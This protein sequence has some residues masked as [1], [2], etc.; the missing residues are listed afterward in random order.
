MAETNVGKIGMDDFRW[1]QARLAE[2]SGNVLEDGRKFLAESRL[3]P[4]VLRHRLPGFAE[5][6]G[7]LRQGGQGDLEAEALDAMTGSDTW[8]FR[9][10]APFDLLRTQII[11][12]LIK[13]RAAERRLI[14]WSAGCATGQEA[15]SLSMLLR[16]HFPVL[17]DWR[18]GILATDFSPRLLAQAESGLFSREQVNRGLPVAMLVKYFSQEGA[19]WRVSAGVRERVRF[20]TLR[21]DQAWEGLPAFDVILMRNVAVYFDAFTR[22][23]TLQRMGEQLAPDGSLLLGSA[24]TAGEAEG[25]ERVEAG[26]SGYFRWK[27]RVA[28][29]MAA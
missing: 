8:F 24:E 21:L 25:L 20:R 2:A 17:Q 1:L 28:A 3:A 26:R 10:V 14:L 19:D 15:Y 7:L 13:A 5:L 11:P 22:A 27:G 16:E 18:V 29:G 4:L 6:F 12:D 9:D 23:Q